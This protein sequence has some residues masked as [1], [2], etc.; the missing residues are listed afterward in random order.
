MQGTTEHLIVCSDEH[1]VVIYTT[2]LW[3]MQGMLKVNVYVQVS[4]I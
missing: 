3:G 1:P 4:T 2:H